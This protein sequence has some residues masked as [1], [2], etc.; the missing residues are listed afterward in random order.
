[1]S[2]ETGP[3]SVSQTADD[4]SATASWL[5]P[6]RLALAS[7]G[8]LVFSFVVALYEIIEVVGEPDAFL[9]VVGGSLVFATLLSRV[10]REE[11]AFVIGAVLLVGGIWSYASALGVDVFAMQDPIISDVM[12]LL[13]G[14]SVLRLEKIELWVLGVTPAPV[15]LTWYLAMRR[16]YVAAV[17]AG[18]ATLTFFVLTGDV[19]TTIALFGVLGAAGTIGFGRLER[20]GGDHSTTDVLAVVLAAMVVL[21]VTVSV[22]PGGS[23]QPF[24]LFGKGGDRTIE[25]S[26]M[27]SDQRLTIQGSIELSPKARFT[28][29]SDERAYW[30]VAAY[31]R[32]T[33]DGWV[34]SGSSQKYPGQLPNPP[35]RYETIEQRYVVESRL[36]AMPAAWRPVRVSETD[37]ARVS[38]LA[39]LRPAT[40]FT[41]GDSYRVTSRR[42]APTT[43]ELEAAGDDYPEGLED[44]YTQLP[45]TIPDRVDERA[46]RITADADTPYEAA[47]RIEQHLEDNKAYS[48]DVERPDGNIADSFLFEMNEGYCTYYAT[49]MATMLRTQDIPARFVTG[50]T[51][52]EKTAEDEYVV[53]GLD[54]H[55]WVEVYFPEIGWVKFD[56]T[57]A[58]PRSDAEQQRL[59]E[60]GV[61]NDADIDI[62]DED[63]DTD[64]P[65]DTPDRRTADTPTPAG[66]ITPTSPPG[67]QSTTQSGDDRTTE[68]ETT[69]PDREDGGLSL[70][71]PP[72]REQLA[73]ALVVVAG[74]A[75][76]VR[77]TG[78]AERAYRAVWLRWQPRSDPASDVERAFARLEYV[79]AREHRPRRPGETPRQY[80]A[81]IGADP[82]V[83]QVYDCYER[84]RY[85]GE[86]TEQVA[87]R[88]VELVNE[89][90]S[91]RV[92]PFGN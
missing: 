62:D 25:A 16:R 15:F 43:A 38:A 78:A 79:L 40:P 77:R 89:V 47:T 53:R 61:S 20:F 27:N 13:T 68:P 66:P 21:T 91:D 34:R 74:L 24:Q 4:E 49:T 33:G 14:L 75:A 35:G 57:P 67:W 36:N 60:A 70:P 41:A 9:L 22:V 50:Y 18:G 19:G 51:P 86:T 80:L 48:L 2:T 85:A 52:G 26:L 11:I 63:D 46:D 90:V 71:E 10:L 55:A 58:G 8:T 83:E 12:S 87:D 76:G 32:Y 65:T 81:A 82:R 72:S 73:L 28:V 39:G 29:E 23:G 88:A 30:R 42:P 44:R 17:V 59:E 5:S 69:A 3:E 54:S 1:M 45:A 92:G 56:P 31:N 6:R 7:A 64:T 37:N 84:A